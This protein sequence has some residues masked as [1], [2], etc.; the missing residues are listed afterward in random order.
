MATLLPPH[1][2]QRL[3][4]GVELEFVVA[5][6]VIKDVP[7]PSSD[8]SKITDFDISSTRPITRERRLA[9]FES[10]ITQHNFYTAVLRGPIFAS[11]FDTLSQN[12][13]NVTDYNENPDQWTIKQDPSVEKTPPR[14]YR[15]PYYYIGVE[16]TSPVLPFSEGLREVRKVVDLITTNYVAETNSTC[17]LH[18]HLSAG[19]SPTSTISFSTLR[20]LCLFLWAFEPQ[21]DSL[22]PIS[23][24]ASH[25]GTSYS[26]SSRLCSRF[27]QAFS[28]RF[29]ADP[30][31]ADGV[32][33]FLNFREHARAAEMLESTMAGRDQAYNRTGVLAAVK[34]EEGYPGYAVKPTI[35]FRQHEGSLSPL[36]IENWIRVIC[37]IT[38]QL[39]G[40]DE[41]EVVTLMQRTTSEVWEKQGGGDADADSQNEMRYGP[42]P[43]DPVKGT[44]TI[45]HLLQ[46]L[47]LDDLAT[48]YR[49]RGLH[50]IAGRRLRQRFWQTDKQW[51]WEHELSSFSFTASASE[52]QTRRELKTTFEILGRAQGA[53]SA[54][55]VGVEEEIFDKDDEMWG[56]RWA[57]KYAKR[58]IFD[59][60]AKKA[61]ASKEGGKRTGTRP[62]RP[63]QAD[64]EPT[65]TVFTDSEDSEIGLEDRMKEALE[66]GLEDSE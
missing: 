65:L 42:T 32:I 28:Q 6:H 10:P 58:G 1:E 9:A 31:A 2:P 35:E 46:H 48:Y 43:S 36:A 22:H 54:I 33:H 49:D 40:M 45:I 34:G 37:G 16:V 55:G 25:A 18:V 62:S 52:M 15:G 21:L 38:Q 12:R 51:I 11:I 3:Y 53:L 27:T 66:Q 4:F 59:R 29:G 19:P 61:A 64:S 63:P 41:L 20:K 47:G 17:G 8:H 44:F 7:I 24:S 26:A 30:G 60:P 57:S 13:I 5:E 56:V 23:R 14:G 50:P 39:Q